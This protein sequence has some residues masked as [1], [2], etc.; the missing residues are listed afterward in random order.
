M[1]LFVT[2]GLYKPFS[3]F[4]DVIVWFFGSS[5]DLCAVSDFV[6]EVDAVFSPPVG[7]DGVLLSPCGAA[8][9]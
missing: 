4:P 3:A 7:V 1:P 5:P 8:H 2:L 9:I 6:A